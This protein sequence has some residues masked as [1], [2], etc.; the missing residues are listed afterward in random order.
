MRLFI[1][2]DLPEQIKTYLKQLQQQLPDA[3]LSRAK[4]FHLTLKFLGD[5]PE[6]KAK[7]IKEQLN[8]INFEKFSLTLTDIGCFPN[9]KSP[10]VVWVGIK[11]DETLTKLQNDVDNVL[12]KLNF[13]KDSRFHPH[14]TLARIKF[15]KDK[16]EFTNNLKQIKTDEKTFDVKHFCL[17]KS[18]LTSEGAMY[19]ILEKY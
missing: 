2:I 18:T 16:K 19:E 9:E 6:N 4:G 11:E 13:K 3:K 10:R 12:N 17:F 7:S 14:F 8:I 5:V 1:A 15:I